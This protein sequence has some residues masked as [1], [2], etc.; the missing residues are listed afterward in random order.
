[1]N[2]TKARLWTAQEAVVQVGNAIAESVNINNFAFD[3]VPASLWLR[4]RQADRVFQNRPK[5]LNGHTRRKVCGNWRED[6]SPMKRSANGMQKITLVLEGSN[7]LDSLFGQG[8]GQNAIIGSGEEIIV[9]F[10]YDRFALTTDAWVNNYDM[11]GAFRKKPVTRPQGKSARTD[12][13]R[14]DLMSDVH[15]SG[16]RGNAENDPFHR[17]DKPVRKAEVGGQGDKLHQS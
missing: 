10:S 11:Q 2:L 12:V 9:R 13:T 14:W 8:P 5:L 1:M 17:P 7:G 6:V 3:S 4:P 15:D 16:T